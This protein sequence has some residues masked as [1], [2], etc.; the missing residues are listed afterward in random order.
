MAKSPARVTLLPPAAVVAL[1]AASVRTLG[2]LIV[3]ACT[4][5]AAALITY[6][7]SDPSL[8]TASPGPIANALN[9]PGA[10]LADVLLQ[11]GGL[12]VAAPLLVVTLWGMRLLTGRAV[13][14]LWSRTLVLLAGTLALALALGGLPAP[15]DWSIGGGLGGFAGLLL[16]ERLAIGLALAGLEEGQAVLLDTT[17]MGLGALALLGLQWAAVIAW[18]DYAA[19][20][21][22]IA[23]VGTTLAGAVAGLRRRLLK[24]PSS[25]EQAPQPA[26]R[27]AVPAS[28]P[29]RTRGVVRR[30]PQLLPLDT[31]PPT[32]REGPAIIAPRPPPGRTPPPRP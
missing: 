18:H 11:G 21:R 3:L 15:A 23:R 6:S 27:A 14:S 10:V 8:N 30:E 1:K 20:L 19:T 7:P 32:D 12:A 26:A 2:A 25:P 16:R 5:V 13:P 9:L 22:S 31:L 4:A 17:T 24:T 29:A 28:T